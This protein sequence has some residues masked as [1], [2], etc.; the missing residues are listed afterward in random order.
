MMNALVFGDDW[1]TGTTKGISAYL[2]DNGITVH[3]FG[4][5]D[6]GS[7]PSIDVC[8]CTG[9]NVSGQGPDT[10]AWLS[11]RIVSLDIPLVLIG[12]NSTLNRGVGPRAV[13]QLEHNA[14]V[15]E[16]REAGEDAPE[17]AL[18]RDEVSWP[19]AR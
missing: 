3:E 9:V 10:D 1:S 2:Q 17:S 13:M 6:D 5:L 11:E 7:L 12:T 15:N 16:M 18:P 8:I 14:V 19:R 4:Q